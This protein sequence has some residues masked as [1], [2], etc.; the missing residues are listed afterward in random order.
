MQCGAKRVTAARRRCGGR[1]CIA[2]EGGRATGR[3][4]VGDRR[5]AGPARRAA[6][7]GATSC[8]DASG[9]LASRACRAQYCNKAEERGGPLGADADQR[10]KGFEE[11]RMPL[12]AVI[13]MLENRVLKHGACRA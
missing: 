10:C 9:A 7:A 2:R 5:G 8:A 13:Q 4:K 11:I 1:R 6:P 12:P 3:Q